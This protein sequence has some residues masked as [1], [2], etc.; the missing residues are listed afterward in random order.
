M[1]TEERQKEKEIYIFYYI[2]RDRGEKKKKL[3][4]YMC[5]QL[6]SC[7]YSG[8]KRWHECSHTPCSHTHLIWSS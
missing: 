3:C 7:I 2:V 6:K 8:G 4:M 5:M 1:H